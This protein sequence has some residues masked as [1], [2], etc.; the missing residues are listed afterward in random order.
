MNITC[1]IEKNSAYGISAR[2]KCHMRELEEWERKKNIGNIL[3]RK[4]RCGSEDLNHWGYNR[5]QW[6]TSVSIII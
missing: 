2:A 4:I 6:R 1:Q 3:P 5:D